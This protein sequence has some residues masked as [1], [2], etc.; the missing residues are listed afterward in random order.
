M[1]V[2]GR[3]LLRWRVGGSSWVRFGVEKSE[4]MGAVAPEA[5]AEIGS[6]A[7]VAIQRVSFVARIGSTRLGSG[8][9]CEGCEKRCVGGD[10]RTESASSVRVKKSPTR[11]CEEF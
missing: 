4:S 3:T 10:E 11:W 5:G 7:P 1:G 8:G 6:R 9:I 2:E